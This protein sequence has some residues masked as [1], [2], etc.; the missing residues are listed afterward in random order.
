MKI[1]KKKYFAA[2]NSAEGFKSYYS[3][4]FDPSEYSKIYVIKGG[5]GT[6]KSYFLKKAAE[7]AEL[8]GFSVIYIYCSSDPNSLDGIIVEGAGIAMLDGTSPHAIE[9]SA[10]GAIEN[11]VDLGAFWNT[12]MLAGSRRIIEGL[13]RQKS[14]C[15]ERAYRYL[16]AYKRASENMEDAIRPH[17]KTEKI[18]KYISRFIPDEEGEGRERYL[19]ADSIGMQGRVSFDTYRQSAGIYYVIKDHFEA[20][21]VLL[22]A[23]YGEL[24]KKRADMTISFDPVLS[25]RIN[26]ITLTS[27]GLTFRIGA[28]ETED[29]GRVINM[30]RFV[31]AGDM[32]E[33]R[34]D[35]RMANRL[36][37]GIEEL[38]LHELEKAKKYHFTLEEIY[39]GAMDFSAKDRFCTEF[40][41]KIFSAC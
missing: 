39:G 16:A 6:G 21:H 19:L 13:N 12:A 37:S 25:D 36:R 1:I 20:G 10:P 15:F 34:S 32:Q 24:K 11:I 26:A 22:S 38:A 28:D 31:D 9:C 4:V 30:K 40:C 33:A 27:S 17:I 7:H 35:Y 3:N 29:A 41:N 5:P 23:L 14:R 2:S 18:K 8:C